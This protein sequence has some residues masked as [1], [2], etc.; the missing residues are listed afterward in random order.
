MTEQIP[1]IIDSE[2]QFK[3]PDPVNGGT[4]DLSKCPRCGGV[5]RDWG[6]GAHMGDKPPGQSQRWKCMNKP[7]CGLFEEPVTTDITRNAARQQ[8]N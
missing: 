5:M 8:I 1:K 4:M 7:S 2:I 3:V 6:T